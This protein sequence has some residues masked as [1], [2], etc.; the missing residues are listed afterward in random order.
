MSDL[1]DFIGRSGDWPPHK[2]LSIDRLDVISHHPPYLNL[3]R[4]TGPMP[5]G[6]IANFY[7]SRVDNSGGLNDSL[8][9][10]PKSR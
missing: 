7:V 5:T 1:V 8:Q 2:P 6:R 9:D 10:A 3:C 4:G